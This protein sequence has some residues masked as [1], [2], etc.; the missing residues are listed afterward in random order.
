MMLNSLASVA[1]AAARSRSHLRRRPAQAQDREQHD[2]M[3][4][5]RA[6]RPD[7]GTDVLLD[8]HAA[9]QRGDQDRGLGQRRH[10]VAE[11]GTAR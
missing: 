5:R 7:H 4:D 10:L 11:V 6:R 1:W 2:A 8:G 9:D 3:H